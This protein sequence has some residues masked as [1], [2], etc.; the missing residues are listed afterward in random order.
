MNTLRNR[1]REFKLAGM[2]NS[3]DER[4]EYAKNKN[5]S[6][7]EF[8]ELL[9]ED[10]NNNRRD[11]SYKKRYNKAKFPAHKTIEDFDFSF[12]PSINQKIINDALVCH[13]V[14]EHRNIVF[15]GNPGV[16]KTHLA[17]AIGQSALSKN[18][19][20]LYSSVSEMLYQLHISKADNSYYKKM[21]EY[22]L[23]DLLILDELGFKKI[24]NYSSDDFFEIIS[25]RYERGSCIITTNKQFEQWGDIFSDSILAS[26]IIDRV[27]HHSTI[28]KINGPSYRS[29]KLK[30]AHDLKEQT[31]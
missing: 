14:K 3:L 10:E 30:M 1:L 26:A 9:C 2:L 27:V 16:G 6:H 12:Q 13:F 8:I 28:F 4:L 31:I 5:L 17:V 24:P 21:Q 22:L 23:P 20:V 25:K 29:K 18:F 15:I 19:K 11:N 7:V